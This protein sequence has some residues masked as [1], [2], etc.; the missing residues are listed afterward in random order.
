MPDKIAFPA[1]ALLAA[2]LIALALVAPQG[3]GA[4]SPAPFG[5]PLAKS[6]AEAQQTITAGRNTVVLRGREA[7]A[8]NAIID[9]TP[10][11]VTRGL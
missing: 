11:P 9:E 4:R 3:Q 10:S 2:G 5:R 7:E 8:V 1:L 6:P